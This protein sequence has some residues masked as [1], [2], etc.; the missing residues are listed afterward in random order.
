MMMKMG[1]KIFKLSLIAVTALIFLACEK[2]PKNTVLQQP[3][4]VEV[5]DQKRVVVKIDQGPYIGMKKEALDRL[6][7]YRSDSIASSAT[8]HYGRPALKEEI[9]L[10][11]IDIQ[12]DG[13]GLPKGSGTVAEGTAVYAAK[14]AVC[15]GPKGEG[16]KP[17]YTTLSFKETKG[18]TIGSFWPYSTT[19]FDYVRRAMPFNTPG[20]LTDNEVYALTA[21]LLHL[22]EIIPEDKVMNAESLPK[23]VMPNADGFA[24]DDRESSNSIH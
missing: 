15:H 12:P 14:C 22:N 18:K 7:A 9:A 6:E 17:Y 20:T 3:E 24:S 21:F 1:M 2:S 5:N 8:Y 19:I 23:V 11:D 13:Q 4:V 16:I 10:W